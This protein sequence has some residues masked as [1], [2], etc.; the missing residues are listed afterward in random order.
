ML[1]IIRKAAF[2]EAQLMLNTHKKTGAF[3]TDI[4]EQ[5]SAKINQFKY[6]LLDHLETLELS[7]DPNDPLIRCLFLYCPPLMRER[8]GKGILAMPEIHKKAVIAC[9]L[10]SHLVYI[11]GLDW[12]PSVVDVLPMIAKD[13]TII[14]S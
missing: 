6:E 13:P 14:G 7:K 5:I 11:R 2:N 1:E 12:N 4:S 8:Y 9:Y 10:A 3:L